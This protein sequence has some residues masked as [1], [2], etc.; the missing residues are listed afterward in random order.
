MDASFATRS[1]LRVL[2]AV[3]LLGAASAGC[4]SDFHSAT[5]GIRYR[6]P[7]GVRLVAES[8]EAGNPVA[9]FDGGSTSSGRRR[10]SIGRQLPPRRHGGP[11]PDGE[12]YRPPGR[13]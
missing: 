1:R 8:V 12:R 13:W 3:V 2:G 6:P 5:L 7:N 11:G 4:D 10:P 9:R